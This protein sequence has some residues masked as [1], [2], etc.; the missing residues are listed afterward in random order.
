MSL[1]EA[2]YNKNF[3]SSSKEIFINGD[4]DF[5]NDIQP[6]CINVRRKEMADKIY[7]PNVLLVQIKTALGG[8]PDVIGEIFSHSK[9]SIDS[10]NLKSGTYTE[11]YKE[12]KKKVENFKVTS[13]QKNIYDS[14]SDEYSIKYSEEESD[15]S[16]NMFTDDSTTTAIYFDENMERCF[17]EITLDLTLKQ[18]YELP[19]LDKKI[20]H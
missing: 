6:Y 13:E 4:D 3:L 8:A 2:P 18:N 14:D 7:G 1:I 10:R 16:D 5:L 19:N 20:K 17:Q 9:S 12:F 15:L 11:S